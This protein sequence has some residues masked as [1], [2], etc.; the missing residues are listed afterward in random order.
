VKIAA[1]GH[2]PEK[3]G[4]YSDDVLLRLRHL[5]IAYLE[6]QS[7][8]TEAISGMALGWDT[9]WA[10]AAID[11]GIP[12]CAA[13]P[14]SGQD[15]RWPTPSRR[16]YN[17]I[18]HN[19]SRIVYVC[20]PGYAAFKMQRRNE[21]MIS[22]CDLLVAL[23]DGSSGGTANC[24]RAAGGKPIDNLWPEFAHAKHNKPGT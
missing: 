1:T 21:W 23:W 14:F 7:G 2:R 20:D 3:L 15:S 10:L 4:G 6:R 16:Q 22:E 12:L 24:I 17:T 11:C 9:A 19:A 5:A 18:L 8:I 13:I